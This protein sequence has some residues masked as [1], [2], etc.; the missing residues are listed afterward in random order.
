MTDGRDK[1]GEN[2]GPVGAPSR[3]PPGER[4]PSAG[5][6]PSGRD[7]V[8]GDLLRQVAVPD[9]A[10]GYWEVL[11]TRLDAEEPAVAAEPAPAAPSAAPSAPVTDEGAVPAARGRQKRP[12]GARRWWRPA[13]VVP[14]AAAVA[15]LLA[16]VA[17]GLPGFAP[18]QPEPATAADVVARVVK[19]IDGLKTVSGVLVERRTLGGDPK[20]GVVET[21]TRFWMDADG[22]WAQSGASEGPE[23]WGEGTR[24]LAFDAASARLTEVKVWSKAGTPTYTT[25]NDAPAAA[26]DGAAFEALRF[27]AFA[28]VVG[29]LGGAA[30]ADAT[31][32]GAGHDGRPAWRLAAARQNGD[33]WPGHADGMELLVDEATAVPVR[34]TLSRKGEVIAEQWVEDLT[35]NE[36]V[37]AA[38]FA[39]VA[40]TGA[41][42]R[43]YDAG[44]RRLEPAAIAAALPFAAYYPASVP[45]GFAPRGAA[46][47]RAE[48][49][50]AGAGMQ[51]EALATPAALFSWQ[52]GFD[53]LSISTR[54]YARSVVY[55][56]E[57][58]PPRVVEDP[59]ESTYAWLLMRTRPRDVMLRRGALAGLEAHV[60]AGA[61]AYPHLWVVVPAAIG[62]EKLV[63]TVAG[64]ATADEL[65]AVAESLAPLSAPPD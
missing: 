47:A 41:Q 40:P 56:G 58:L 26:P 28:R 42:R 51:W 27:R 48:W 8:V 11:G 15:G 53:D 37:A 39:P 16:I 12:T 61:W 64:D 1:H 44:Y 3:R 49:R 57:G 13:F 33:R 38:R 46:L 55:E 35:V 29:A 21:S 32:T 9:H 25:W 5:G 52:R 63:V 4:E 30:L 18:S 24:T 22:D 43:E 14:V 54:P 6:E 19:A 20:K 17:F 36:P 65:V 34:W 45:R 31:L 2:T 7:P 50:D 23:A 60:V 62:G 59:F 10:P